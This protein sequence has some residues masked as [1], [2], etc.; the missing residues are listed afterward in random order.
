MLDATP[1]LLPLSRRQMTETLTTALLWTMAVLGAWNGV[2]MIARVYYKVPV[3]A[4]FVACFQRGMGRVD[5]VNTLKPPLLAAN[6]PHT[7]T[8]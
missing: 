4:V 1:N 2:N 7:I 3:V 8:P 6:P 5:S